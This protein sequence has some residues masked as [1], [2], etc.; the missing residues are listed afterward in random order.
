[1]KGKS[2]PSWSSV[3]C[4]HVSRTKVMG[5]NRVLVLCREEVW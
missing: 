2:L 4:G 3:S 5:S 1:M